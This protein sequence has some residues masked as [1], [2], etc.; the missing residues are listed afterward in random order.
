MP[1]E[2]KEKRTRGK[3]GSFVRKNFSIGQGQEEWL[4]R[5][6][7]ESGESESFWIRRA[8]K[9]YVEGKEER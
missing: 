9:Y 6:R 7:R 2:A 3:V 1:E 8:I 5:K 4:K